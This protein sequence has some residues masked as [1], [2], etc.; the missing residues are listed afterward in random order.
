MI[1]L[2]CYCILTYTKPLSSFLCVFV[3]C[4]KA[5]TYSKFLNVNGDLALVLCVMLSSCTLIS[6]SFCMLS[7][8]FAFIYIAYHV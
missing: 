5:T 6:V 1:L 3:L 4:M 2:D 7:F 8:I